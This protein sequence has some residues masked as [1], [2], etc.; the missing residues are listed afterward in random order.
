MGVISKVDFLCEAAG[1]QRVDDPKTLFLI[2]PQFLQRSIKNLIGPNRCQRM[3]P[4]VQSE[5]VVQVQIQFTLAKR[6]LRVPDK[7][8]VKS[9]A[10]GKDRTAFTGEKRISQR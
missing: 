8:L 5:F 2:L 9:F 4:S 7:F 3:Y 10:V 1:I 6:V